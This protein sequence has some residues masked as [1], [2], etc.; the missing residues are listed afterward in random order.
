[1]TFDPQ[2]GVIP[3]KTNIEIVVKLTPLVGGYFNHV[4][5]CDV[6]GID[7]PLGFEIIT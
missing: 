2:T 6:E 5:E 1:V 3:A 4:F 7:F